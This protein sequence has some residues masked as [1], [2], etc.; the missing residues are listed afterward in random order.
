MIVEYMNEKYF[1]LGFIIINVFDALLLFF[2]Y[3][4]FRTVYHCLNFI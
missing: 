3:A 1:V 4:C 2:I